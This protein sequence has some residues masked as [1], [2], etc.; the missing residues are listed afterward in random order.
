MIKTKPYNLS[1]ENIAKE[2]QSDID[3][4]LS[5][6]IAEKRLV[7][8]GVNQLKEKKRISPL[9]IFIDQFKDFIVWIL[10]GAALVSG[11]LSEWIDAIA[12]VT[13]VLLNSILGFIQEYRAEKSLAAL[14]KL[15]S[16]TSKVIRN[17][18]HQVISSSDIVPGDLI[19]MEAGDN[20]P[21]DGRIVY[22]SAN[23]AV[24]EASL[25]GESTPV[26]KISEQLH[27]DEIPLADR[28]N[29][30][31]LGT[32]VAAGKARA[33]IVGTGMQTELGKIAGM[34]Q[35][36]GE[37]KTPLQKKLEQFGKWIVYLCFVLVALVFFMEWL[38]GGAIL[39]V[40][41]TSVSLAVAAIPEG[42][43]A[44]VTIALA[45]GVQRMVKRHALIRKL[46]SVETLGCTTVICSDKTGTL[47]KNEMT[48]SN[49]F[50]SN[51]LF[52]V[53]G[54]GYE[55]KG[56]ILLN[57]EKIDFNNDLTLKKT[58]LCGVLCNGSQLVSDNGIYSII[59][60]PTEGALLT[61]AGKV[62]LFKD[63]LEKQQPFVMELP[64]DSVRKKMTI[65]REQ[66]GKYIAY[67]KGAPDILLEDCVEIEENGK[68]SALSQEAKENILKANSDLSNKAMRV[69]AFAFKI[70]DHLPSQDE[71]ASIEKGLTF[72]GLIS[73]IDPPRE[74]AKA[75]IAE[76]RT[77]GI[78]TVMIT[79]DHKNT[80]VAIAKELGFFHENSLA[81]TGEELDGLNDDEFFNIVGTTPVYARVSPENKLRIIR[82]LRAQGEIV[83]MT[84]DGVNDAPA[85]KE[86][87][88]GIAMG[89]TGTDVTKE[90]SDMVI[91]DDNFASIVAAVKEGRGIYDNIKKF[92]HY[93]LSCNA[94]EILVMFI[95]S[96]MGLPIPLFPIQL[97]W[98]NLVTDGFPALALG[99]D[100]V[101]ANVMKRP[102][103]PVNEGVV[104]GG[105]AI[106]MITQGF[107]LAFCSLFAFV[108]VLFVERESI[109]HAR[110]AAFVVL[111]CSQLFHS[112][113]CRSN[114][115]SI[116]KLGFFTNKQLVLAV[117]VSFML[118][119]A[120]VYL[121]FFQII[122]KTEALNMTDWL[123]VL[124]VSSLPLWMMEAVKLL[125]RKKI[126]FNG[127]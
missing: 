107:F 3:S 98:V 104:T 20:V 122:F 11:F 31:Y 92:I 84:G 66:N 111:A 19:E 114:K 16:P 36:I 18:A 118:Q 106:L 105:Q 109:C 15:S 50:T 71:T 2:L 51:T 24:Q 13:I 116:F 27:E 101:S 58:L 55:P 96:L 72:L 119:M 75:A 53:T 120:V 9:S 56:E 54:I 41:L 39:D 35:D 48:V 69:L 77:A 110:T 21:A 87:D 123:F 82:A 97:L 49:I 121:P 80:A 99:V 59:G 60:D 76:C 37:E 115:D 95:S 89:I 93:L 124:F 40:F 83:A 33:I 47:T 91:T 61:C 26:A 52:Y 38:R 81:L 90:V 17:Y 117:I 1:P 32:S 79:G 7:E 43:P 23:L 73:M 125:G 42:L 100:P 112:F 30:V 113:N 108:F 127:W 29:M 12:I 70:L 28:A 64:F 57:R 45:L 86:S 103:R 14:K 62:L 44:V 25:T 6:D 63:E 102:P 126:Q 34:I 85:L 22:A 74:E 4:G 10:I 68:A 46:P 78:K 8:F 94:G 67:V 5:D 88:I 65:V